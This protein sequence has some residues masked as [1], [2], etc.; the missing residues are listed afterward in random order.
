MPF[1]FREREVNVKRSEI[2]RILRENIDFLR[3]QKFALPPFAFWTPE[4]W[5]SKGHECDEIRENRL[6][7]DVTD[8]GSGDFEKVGLFLFTLRNGN[9]NMP[10]KYPKTYAEKVMAVSPG[11]VTPFHFHWFKTE[12]IINRGGGVLA[13]RLFNADEN[14]GLL[15]EK[16]PVKVR[17][18]G[19]IYDL[20][21][22]GIV[23]L[24]PGESITLCPGQYHAF[25]A[26]NEKTLVGE[27]SQCNDDSKDNRFLEERGRFPA[28][29][30]DEAP[31]CLLCTEYPKAE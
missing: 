17:S 30:E 14:T 12:D 8:F 18:D 10:E 15:D 23:R 22:G 5:K 24:A 20:P 25:W 27:V 11:Q 29:E 13:V 3:G 31:L 9:R 1:P 16:T 28:I 4:E 6:G 2:N 26:E 21:A 7:W 19:R